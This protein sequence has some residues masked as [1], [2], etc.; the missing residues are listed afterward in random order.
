MS[1]PLHVSEI[2]YSIQGEG[3]TAGVPAMFLRL[4][5]CHVKCDWCD[6]TE[7]WKKGSPMLPVTIV[8]KMSALSPSFVASDQFRIILTGGSPLL[9][10]PALEYFLEH[11][12]NREVY[13]TIEMETEGTIRP[14]E[15]LSGMIDHHTISPKLAN[16]GVAKHAR[17]I[18]D[19]LD[20]YSGMIAEGR[21][22]CFKFVVKDEFCVEEAMEM[23]AEHAISLKTVMFMPLASSIEELVSS[24]KRVA[25]LALRCG[26][27]FSPRLQ[28]LI[29]NKTTGV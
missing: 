6:T 2:F 27:G 20:Y 18:P 15:S 1:K 22:V 21:S 17:Y 16:S 26:V 25:E 5:G 13:P 23:V 4:Q 8:E 29:W 19:V 3:S 10:Q 12:S 11:L 24:S 9:Q 14:M 7:V 28:I